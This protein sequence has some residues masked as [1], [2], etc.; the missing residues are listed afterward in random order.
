MLE[1]MHGWGHLVHVN[2]RATGKGV[3][4]VG[5]QLCA[6]EFASGGSTM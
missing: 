1:G 4:V 3:F 6:A 2:G 5:A